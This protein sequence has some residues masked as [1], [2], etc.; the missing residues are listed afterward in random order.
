LRKLREVNDLV[1]HDLLKLLR[2]PAEERRWICSGSLV[3]RLIAPFSVR[4]PLSLSGPDCCCA[5]AGG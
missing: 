4:F 2:D 3:V 5:G 1:T